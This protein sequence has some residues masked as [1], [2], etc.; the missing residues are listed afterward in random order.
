MGQITAKPKPA[1][2]DRAMMALVKELSARVHKLDPQKVFLASDCIGISGFE[3]VPGYAMMSHGTYQDT[4]CQPAAWSYGLFPNWRNALWSCNWACVSNFA[5]MRWGVQT[6]GV[7]VA[8]SNGWG[9]DRGPWEWTAVEREMFRELFRQRLAK[10]G[11]VRYLTE[12]PQA[13][14]ARGLWPSAPGDPLP[15]AAPGTIN[16]AL[17]KNEARGSASS[18]DPAYSPGGVLDG[19]RDDSGWSAGHGWA[20]AA[21]QRLPQWIE[22]DFGRT[23]EINQVIVI[24]YQRE[25]S[26]ETATKWGIEDYEVQ[27]WDAAAARWKT[28]ASE[29]RGRAVKVRVH[30]L[31]APVRTNKLRL[32]VSRVAPPDARARL[33]QFEAWGAGTP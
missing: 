33:L 4:G 29:A 26:T 27:A 12:D 23:R 22:V 32:T 10:S 24:T 20:S 9:D 8:I 28:V 18:T 13:L 30:R 17:T 5:A 15:A 31:D 14:I 6:F 3:D 1:Y 11:R 16:W 25:N 21:G 19:V 7:P 2:C